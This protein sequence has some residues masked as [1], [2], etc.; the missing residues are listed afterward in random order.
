MGG[1]KFLSHCFF[2]RTHLLNSDT[3]CTAGYI[4]TLS[5]NQAIAVVFCW[6]FV[7]SLGT[8]LSVRVELLFRAP[9]ALLV[10][11][12]QCLAGEQQSQQPSAS[13]ALVWKAAES[14][15]EC[16]PDVSMESS[17]VSNRVRPNVSMESS[18]ASNRVRSNV[19]MESSRVS[20]RVRPRR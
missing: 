5:S 3:C 4:S 19:S 7:L 17:R 11:I 9:A 20:N 8:P 6:L 12:N 18:I 1:D 15:T 10:R 13:Q 2:K 16:V 14:A